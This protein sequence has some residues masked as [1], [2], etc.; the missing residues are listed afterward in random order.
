MRDFFGLDDSFERAVPQR[1]WRSDV[2]V[3]A[4]L[5]LLSALGLLALGWGSISEGE[6]NLGLA[7]LAIAV[8]GVLLTFRRRYPVLVL[9]LLTGVHFVLVGELMW[10]VAAQ[11]G[12]QI[13]YFLGLY[14]A[15]AWARNREGLLFATMAVLLTMVIWIIIAYARELPMLEI[16]APIP[17]MLSFEVAVNIAYFATALWL[18]RHAWL[19]AKDEAELAASKQVIE[20]QSKELAEK[21]IIGERLRISRELHDSIAHHVA[22]IGIRAGAARRTLEKKPE[23]AAR[24]LQG[25]EHAARQTV[26]ELQHIVGSLREVETSNEVRPDLASLPALCAEFEAMGL[27][28]EHT[29]LGSGDTISAVHAATLYRVIQEA[30]SNVRRHST[31]RLA[32]ITVRIEDEFV[33]A[34]ILDDGR[35]LSGTSGT[36]VGLIG[37]RERVMALNGTTQIGP[38]PDRGYRV[39]VRIPLD[40]EENP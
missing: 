36:R 33:E 3:A 16:D 26:G 38:R 12:M 7:L 13:A 15:M 8:A 25:V 6:I 18:G 24:A 31:A 23:E 32:R 1:F 9:L 37:I 20:D 10:M 35:P 39:L 30:L 40:P 2:I 29:I 27:N 19:K 28:T 11:A 14:S 21:A 5:C 4:V 34:E 22:L 17:L